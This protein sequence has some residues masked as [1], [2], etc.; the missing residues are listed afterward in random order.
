MNYVKAI[1]NSRMLVS[2]G[3]SLINYPVNISRIDN[4]DVSSSF[5]ELEVC[6]IIQ[7]DGVEELHCTILNE[8][9]LLVL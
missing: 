4:F 8:Y 3:Q 5:I 7:E 1:I 9:V 2:N 6:A